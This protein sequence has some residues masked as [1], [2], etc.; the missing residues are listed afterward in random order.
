[1]N[2]YLISQDQYDGYDTFDSVVVASESE[3][4]AKQIHPAGYDDFAGHVS[5]LWCDNPNLVQVKLLGVAIPGTKRGIILA[6]FNAG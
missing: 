1:M 5:C 6:S 4:D 3:N 2:L